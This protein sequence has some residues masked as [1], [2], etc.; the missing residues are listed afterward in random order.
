MNSGEMRNIRVRYTV[1]RGLK[2]G[3]GKC[4]RLLRGR[5]LALLGGSL[6][7]LGCYFCLSFK[8][9]QGADVNRCIHH[10]A[11][12]GHRRRALGDSFLF[13]LSGAGE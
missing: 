9:L 4:P 1:V 5:V 6:L 12:V 11:F 10:L 3:G 8:N 7:I 13:T 2:K